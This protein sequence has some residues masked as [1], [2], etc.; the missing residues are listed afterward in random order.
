MEYFYRE[1]YALNGVT[2]IQFPQHYPVSR[3]LGINY[4]VI[5]QFTTSSSVNSL[6]LNDSYAG[7]V[8]VVGCLTSDELASWEMVPE[9][10]TY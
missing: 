10:V 7:C 6:H 8:E 3:L 1:I 5:S 2:D 4:S 9:G